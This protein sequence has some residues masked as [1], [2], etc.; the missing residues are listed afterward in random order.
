MLKMISEVML[1]VELVWICNARW[2]YVLLVENVWVVVKNAPW[3]HVWL[4]AFSTSNKEYSR[5]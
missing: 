4:D 3:A 2:F 5:I 1:P